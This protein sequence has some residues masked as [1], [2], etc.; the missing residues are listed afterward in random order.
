MHKSSILIASEYECVWIL[1]YIFSTLY[2]RKYVNFFCNEWPCNEW[3]CNEWPCPCLCLF[4]P[5]NL[6]I[7][8]LYNF[9]HT[10]AAFISFIHF[11][12]YLYASLFGGFWVDVTDFHLFNSGAYVYQS[13]NSEIPTW[14]FTPIIG[15]GILSILELWK[16]IDDHITWTCHNHVITLLP[17]WQSCD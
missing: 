4:P 1:R 10:Y 16:T 14:Y 12:T 2:Q 7:I 6:L 13:T 15:L 17:Y 11:G 9:S 8:I 3:P 5:N